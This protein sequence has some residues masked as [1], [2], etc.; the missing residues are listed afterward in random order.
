MHDINGVHDTSDKQFSRS[1]IAGM[2]KTADMRDMPYAPYIKSCSIQPHHVAIRVTGV[3]RVGYIIHT[4][5]MTRAAYMTHVHIQLHVHEHIIPGAGLPNSWPFLVQVQNGVPRPVAFLEDTSRPTPI[6]YK[7][8]P[9]K[10]MM[11]L[12]GYVFGGFLEQWPDDA[13]D[14]HSVHSWHMSCLYGICWDTD[15]RWSFGPWYFSAKKVEADQEAQKVYKKAIEL[16]LKEHPCM[17]RTIADALEAEHH[18]R[19][20]SLLSWGMLSWGEW[21]RRQVFHSGVLA[22]RGPLTWSYNLEGVELTPSGRCTNSSMEEMQ[23][24]CDSDEV[25]ERI[26]NPLAA[27]FS[28]RFYLVSI[29]VW[30]LLKALHD[31]MVLSGRYSEPTTLWVGFISWVFQGLAVSSGML[32]MMGAA[33]VWVSEADG[34]A[35]NGDGPCSC[36]YRLDDARAL[37]LVSTPLVLWYAYFAKQKRIIQALLSGDYLYY[38]TY[39]VPYAVVRQNPAWQELDL[40]V[41]NSRA[42]TSTASSGSPVR[43]HDV[44]LLARIFVGPS[45]LLYFNVLCVQLP[46][47]LGMTA[48]VPRLMMLLMRSATGQGPGDPVESLVFR[49]S[50]MVPAC[51]CGVFAVLSS[52]DAYKRQQQDSDR[53]GRGLMLRIYMFLGVFPVNWLMT[54]VSCIML[55]PPDE[56][57]HRGESVSSA[58]TLRHNVYWA[59]AGG[60]LAGDAMLK[61][62]LGMSTMVEVLRRAVLKEDLRDELPEDIAEAYSHELA[63]HGADD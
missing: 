62:V 45:P 25:R 58:M 35:W 36:F 27:G 14:P 8:P 6:L 47:S 3:A 48:F 17:N 49:T 61:S 16:Y 12:F 10:T 5:L 33:Q 44:R 24:K 55:L 51:A 15:N 31:V 46:F 19:K 28:T 43:A 13:S 21:M 11:F 39:D 9:P 32:A 1:D 63:M 34:T 57:W 7:Q 20:S 37:V 56:V 38:K 53:M 42:A 40:L 60:S 2:T 29:G 18:D 4:T 23:R 50:L 26:I 22:I 30:A 54:L 41:P 52:L 59:I